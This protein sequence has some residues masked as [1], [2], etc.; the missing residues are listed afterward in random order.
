MSTSLALGG[1]NERGPLRQCSMEEMNLE[2]LEGFIRAAFGDDADVM[3]VAL[4]GGL[5]A[6]VGQ[7]VHPS[8][9]GLL[10]FGQCPQWV[11]PQWGAACVRISGQ[12][13]SDPVGARFNAEGALPTMLQGILAF[14]TENTR[15]IMVESDNFVSSP[16][17]QSEYALEGVRELVANALIHRDLKR[18]SR[19]SVV[20]FDDRIVIRSPGGPLFDAQ[21]FDVLANQGGRSIPR[22][23]VLA[24]VARRLELCEQIGRGLVRARRLSAEITRSPIR[25]EANSAEVSVTIP[26]ALVGNLPN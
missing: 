4:R 9:V 22:N 16:N 10:C 26:S 18:T 19:V 14:I 13:M 21:V 24:S 12:T 15:T 2:R 23:P 3:Q 17:T 25:I 5:V 8:A 6:R 1:F 7:Q 20:I 11:F